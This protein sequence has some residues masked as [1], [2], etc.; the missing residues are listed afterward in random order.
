[1]LAS[2]TQKH[3][4]SPDLNCS[5]PSMRLH[6]FCPHACHLYQQHHLFKILS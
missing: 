4:A 3:A 5:N 1:M 2:L 6:D